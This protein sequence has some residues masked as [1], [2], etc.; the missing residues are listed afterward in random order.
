MAGHIDFGDDGDVALSCVLHNLAGLVLSVVTSIRSVVVDI[1]VMAKH[2][3]LTF[4]PKLGEPG[5]LLDFQSPSLV[6]SE[7]PVEGI[8]VVQCHKVDALFD[9]RQREIVTAAVKHETAIAETGLVGD[10]S[11]RQLHLLYAFCHYGQRFAKRLYAIEYSIG[12]TTLDGD[13]LTVHCDDIAFFGFH[14]LVELQLND[15]GHLRLACDH[16]K[17]QLGVVADIA[18]QEVGIAL[19]F[20]TV[21]E[22]RDNR[23]TI[24][25]KWGFTIKGNLM[26]QGH[27][28]VV[29]LSV[30]RDPLGCCKKTQE[31]HE[32]NMFVH[33]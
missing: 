25:D 20:R 16:R 10:G 28:L 2:S 12:G 8:H 19:H 3:S 29:G 9:K 26:G 7:M 31:S 11:R 23:P 17:T 24:E 33:K 22:T 6:L 32:N 27:H 14:L 13:S 18:G 1:A 21:V 30:G 5:I 4:G 15:C